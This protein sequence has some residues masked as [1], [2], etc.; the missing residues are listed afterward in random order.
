MKLPTVHLPTL[1]TALIAIVVLFLILH[2]ISH[3]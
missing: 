2:W 1:V 3:K